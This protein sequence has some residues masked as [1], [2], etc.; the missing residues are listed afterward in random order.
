LRKRDYYDVLGVRKGSSKDE[1]KKKFR[2]LAKKYHPD[3]NKDDKGAAKKFQEVSEAYEVL[4]DDNKR[5]MYDNFGHAAVD[6][7]AGDPG[8]GGN[9]FE[10]FG[11]FGG[12]GGPFGGGGFQGGFQGQ[13]VDIDPEDIMEM[14]FGGGGSRSV[15]VE[16]SIGFFEAVN[17]CEKEVK[18]SYQAK[19]PK[20]PRM[21]NGRQQ[22]VN[23]TKSVKVDIPAGVSDGV[24]LRSSGNGAEGAPGRPAGDLI[25][26]LRVKKDPYFTRRDNDILVDVR[27][28]FYQA[29]LGDVVDV[30]TIDGKVTLKVPPGTQPGQQLRLRGKGVRNVNRP[31]QRGDQIVTI[32]VTLPKPKDLNDEQLELINR[33]KAIERKEVDPPVSSDSGKDEKGKKQDNSGKDG[34]ECGSSFFKTIKDTFTG[35]ETDKNAKSVDEKM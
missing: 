19:D 29:V 16:L 24:S 18:F 26:H 22:R 34:E 20:A 31:T 12:F 14:F 5:Q 15:E 6:G 11:G 7:S 2:E 10:G 28:P 25:I 32:N 3:L 9:P 8:A 1:I 17:G 23:K 35:K 21:R 13:Q 27:I 30:R 33:F 4:E